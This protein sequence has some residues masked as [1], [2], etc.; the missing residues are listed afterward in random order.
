MYLFCLF[1]AKDYITKSGTVSVDAKDT[2]DEA[3]KLLDEL[4]KIWQS[5]KGLYS[6]IINH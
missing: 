4:N 2:Y 6:K 1:Q 5:I 3:Q